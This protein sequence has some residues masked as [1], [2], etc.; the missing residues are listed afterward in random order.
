MGWCPQ[1]DFLARL[2]KSQIWEIEWTDMSQECGPSMHIEYDGTGPGVD[3][4]A[5]YE[6]G[7]V[8]ETSEIIRGH[9]P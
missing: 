7:V 6:R 5:P 8:A 4:N 9:I 1:E 2:Y 3:D